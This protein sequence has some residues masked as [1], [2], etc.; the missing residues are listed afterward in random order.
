MFRTLVLRRTKRSPCLLLYEE[1][2]PF[3]GL[4]SWLDLI[5][6][7]GVAF[8]SLQ[9]KRFLAVHRVAPLVAARRPSTRRD[10]EGMDSRVGSPSSS[11][12][13]FTEPLKLADSRTPTPP[14]PPQSPSLTRLSRARS[15]A[16]LRPPPLPCLPS[17][18]SLVLHRRFPLWTSESGTL[19]ADP[20]SSW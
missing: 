20:K 14:P 11:V 12:R 1:G 7:R 6:A 9:S 4:F 19:L 17:P 2:S 13:L 15:V 5:F 16:S 10:N 8:E 18:S 3:V